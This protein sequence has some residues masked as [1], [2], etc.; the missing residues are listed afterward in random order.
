MFSFLT[1]SIGALSILF[2]F[3][4]VQNTYWSHS[5]FTLIDL[6]FTIFSFIFDVFSC[7]PSSTY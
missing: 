4:Y 1:N 2:L 5:Y 6:N 7:D 3:D